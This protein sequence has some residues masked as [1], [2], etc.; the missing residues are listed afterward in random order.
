MGNQQSA[1]PPKPI[2]DTFKDL[3]NKIAEPFVQAEKTVEIVAKKAV[4]EVKT[5]A[6]KAKEVVIEKPIQETKKFFEE[7]IPTEVKKD[8]KIVTKE[9]KKDFEFVKSNKKVIGDVAIETGKVVKGIGDF[10]EIGAI[11]KAGKVLEKSG[12]LLKKVDIDKVEDRGKKLDD[13]IRHKKD[14]SDALHQVSDIASDVADEMPEGKNK[15]KVK[16]FA[17]HTKTSAKVVDVAIEHAEDI[18][19]AKKGVEQV[20]EGIKTKD[21]GK[22]IKGAGQTVKATS[23]IT[24][25]IPEEFLHGTG[26]D[27]IKLFNKIGNKMPIIEQEREPVQKQVMPKTMGDR[28]TASQED[29][30]SNKAKQRTRNTT[31]KNK[32]KTEDP[33]IVVNPN[34]KI[35]ISKLKTGAGKVKK[36]K[37]TKKRV[38][39][40]K[41]LEK[42]KADKKPV[43]KK[44]AP[45]EDA[46]VTEHHTLQ[47]SS[48][49]G[50][51]RVG[52]NLDVAVAGRKAKAQPK[53]STASPKSQGK[54]PRKLTAYN[55]FVKAHKGKSFKE[56][57][58]LW[59]AKKSSGHNSGH[60]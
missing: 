15:D 49:K 27:V 14:I 22:I 12:T 23:Q 53:K 16:K 18:K 5:T 9:A 4:K 38:R 55:K 57:G 20:V 8:V 40:N 60:N 3:G 36:V 33:D 17:K 25:E 2:A 41:R 13:T 52:N 48:H 7:T 30:S 39:N 10:V 11:S 54:T 19:N 42:V 29:G 47:E 37:S 45:A 28:K 21:K 1:P 43:A 51:G 56:I 59:R 24:T 35:V 50:D 31:R 46:K 32:A 26:G 34:E 6:V 58:A 44:V